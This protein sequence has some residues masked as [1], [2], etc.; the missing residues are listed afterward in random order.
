MF[1]MISE[2]H[3]PWLCISLMTER[4]VISFYRMIYGSMNT[5]HAVPCLVILSD[6]T[7]FLN[8]NVVV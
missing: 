8:D 6:F 4:M 3:C 1:V 2:T 7:S 5:G